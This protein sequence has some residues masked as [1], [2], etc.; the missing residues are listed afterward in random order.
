MI[1]EEREN[2]L[3]IQVILDALRDWSQSSSSNLIWDTTL[4]NVS[5]LVRNCI[6]KEVSDNAVANLVLKD[7]SSFAA[8][9]KE[10]YISKSNKPDTPYIVCYIPDYSALPLAHSRQS[11]AVT[12]RVN[13]VLNL[14]KKEMS[15]EMELETIYGIPVC[16]TSI[17]SKHKFPH[18]QLHE[19]M[20]SCNKILGKNMIRIN[21]RRY[22]MI[23]HNPIDFHLHKAY[24][25][26]FYVLES[27]TGHM[28]E[29]DMFG[30]K[31]F[32]LP[33]IPFNQYTH[34]LFGDSVSV[35]PLAIRA[36]KKMFTDL[37]Y[38]QRWSIKTPEQVKS[39]MVNTG[40]ITSAL[41]STVRF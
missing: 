28:K 25:K 21:T 18:Q 8:S 40:Q 31:V 16:V 15:K 4:I 11:S 33:H 23:S 26:R 29:P 41:L 35:K 7:I 14:L 34:L 10:Y 39:D 36:V 5:T 2:S 27:Y 12:I 13:Q 9:L 3:G 37:A 17:G 20:I 22:V 6:D 38:K 30:V 19:V 1:K 32:K 24:P